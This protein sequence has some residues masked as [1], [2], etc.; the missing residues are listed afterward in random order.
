MS[1]L[2]FYY[3]ASEVIKAVIYTLKSKGYRMTKIDH[4]NGIIKARSRFNIFRGSL[5]LVLIIDEVSSYQTN[6]SMKS[7]VDNSWFFNPENIKKQIEEHF[8]AMLYY[9][10]SVGHGIS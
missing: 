3:P 9:Q 8:T 1:T 7:K 6:L 4:E 10:I 5:D 2:S